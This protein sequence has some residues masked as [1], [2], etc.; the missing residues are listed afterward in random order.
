VH[1]RSLAQGSPYSVSSTWSIASHTA[2][3]PQKCLSD[4]CCDDDEER[5][6]ER[7]GGDVEDEEDKAEDEVVVVVD[8]DD[9]EEKEEGNVGDVA[10]GMKPYLRLTAALTPGGRIG[11][12]TVTGTRPAADAGARASKRIT[13]FTNVEWDQ[14]SFSRLAEDGPEDFGGDCD[15]LTSS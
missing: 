3:I 1:G 10:G 5:E 15:A 11:K 14:G 9:D 7:I 12:S 8:V 6:G 4:L 13:S 2:S